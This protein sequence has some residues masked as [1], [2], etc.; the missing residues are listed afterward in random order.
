MFNAQINYKLR[1]FQL[2]LHK[3]KMTFPLYGKYQTIT[4]DSYEIKVLSITK[5]DTDS[6]DEDKLNS[7]RIVLNPVELYMFNFL[8]EEYKEIFREK[9]GPFLIQRQIGPNTFV[10]EDPYTKEDYIQNCYN[11]RPN[12][13]RGIMEVQFRPTL[14]N[15]EQNKEEE[16]NRNTVF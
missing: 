7:R 6:I 1:T 16:Q 14:D 2:E 8:I 9:V 10:L 3:E 13:T 4:K 15:I 12:K 11:L 5:L